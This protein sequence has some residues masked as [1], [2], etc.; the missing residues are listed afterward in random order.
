MLLMSINM[1]YLFTDAFKRVVNC[2]V[3]V[4]AAPMVNEPLVF[5]QTAAFPQL[6]L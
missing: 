6:F 2:L 4:S 5:V 1:E 3:Q